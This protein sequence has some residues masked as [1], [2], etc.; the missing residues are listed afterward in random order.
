MRVGVKKAEVPVRQH[1]TAS[2]NM[3]NGGYSVGSTVNFKYDVYS[4]RRLAS[5]H[6]VGGG[7]G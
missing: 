2:A 6:L 4:A 5:T 7:G 1:R 3:V